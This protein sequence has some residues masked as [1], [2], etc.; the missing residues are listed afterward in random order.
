MS[1]VNIKAVIR[2]NQW[3]KHTNQFNTI[4]QTKKILYPGHHDIH[5]RIDE[6]GEPIF[7]ESRAIR[8]F[9][10]LRSGDYIIDFENGNRDRALLLQVL[11]D[12]PIGEEISEMSVYK[13][14]G[15]VNYY[16]TNEVQVCLTGHQTKN[17][18]E[19]EI[20]RGFTRNIKVIR[21]IQNTE[22]VFMKYWK[23]QG[24]IIL[25]KSQESRNVSLN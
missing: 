17:Y 24:H 23:F 7:D 25:C 16:G 10:Q 21:Y 5:N 2:Q 15:F 22:T 3:K 11:D 1:T 20:M 19:T 12:T 14:K 9:Q 4:S 18:T 6:N 8:E 13:K